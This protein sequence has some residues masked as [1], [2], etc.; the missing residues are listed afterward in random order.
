[1]SGRIRVG[2][3]IVSSLSGDALRKYRWK[4]AAMVFQSAMNALDPVQTIGSQII[5]TIRQHSNETKDAALAR[6]LLLLEAVKLDVS[7]ASAYPHELSGGMRQRVI[8]A[9]SLCLNPS[10]LIADEPTTGL[11]VVVQ[12]S[13]LRMLKDI[14]DRLGL[15]LILISHDLSIMGAMCDKVAVMYAGKLVEIGDAAR[16]TRDP[17]HP[18]TEALLQSIIEVGK[19]ASTAEGIRGAAPNMLHVPAGCRFHP[20]CRYAFDQCVRSEPRLALRDTTQ[21]ACW[22]RGE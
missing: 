16:V 22:L 21:V 4:E 3:T 20:R 11:D 7:C 15:T 2:S 19:S 18:Y 6:A 8:I 10:L 5:E 12:S 9:L 14:V 17:Q 1:V 13:I